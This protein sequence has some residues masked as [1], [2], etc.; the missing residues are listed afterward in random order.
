MNCLLLYRPGFAKGA[1]RNLNTQKCTDG[2]G[3]GTRIPSV[4]KYCRFQHLGLLLGQN[5]CL[6]CAN[7]LAY[8]FAKKPS[9][10]KKKVCSKHVCWWKHKWTK[11]KYRI[12]T[13]PTNP[14][15][16][17]YFRNHSQVN[18]SISILNLPNQIRVGDRKIQMCPRG[19][20]QWKF[21]FISLEKNL[22]PHG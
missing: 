13:L 18:F 9:Q 16:W 19:N 14:D 20:S 1:F 4:K 5:L 22:S 6:P 17:F 12:K 11:I 15:L 8:S 7:L 21:H 10:E 3:Q 2:C